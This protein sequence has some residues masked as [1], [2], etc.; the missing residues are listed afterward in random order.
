MVSELEEIMGNAGFGELDSTEFE[1]KEEYLDYFIYVKKAFKALN[2]HFVTRLNETSNKK[3][4]RSV[5]TFFITRLQRSIELLNLKYQYDLSHSVRID[6]T[7]S[8]FPNHAELRQMK[9]DYNLKEQFIA[10]LPNAL[11]LKDRLISKLRS[12]KEEPYEILDALS[13]RKYFNNLIPSAIYLMYNTGKMMEIGI[14][15]NGRRSLIYSWSTYDMATNRP[16]VY[17][18]DFEYSGGAEKFDKTNEHFKLFVDILESVAMGSK[19]CYEIIS[20]MDQEMPFLHPKLLKKY[21]IGP[22]Y[23]A[24]SKD[25]H[26]FSKFHKRHKLTKDHFIVYYEE[27]VI[28]SVKEELIKANWISSKTPLQKFHINKDDPECS[29]RKVSDINKYLIAPHT[30]VQ[31]LLDDPKMIKIITPLRDNLVAI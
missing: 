28:A 4:E 20:F 3:V 21:D 24:Y 6:L 1:R 7:D 30:V 17:V 27:E 25:E 10:N 31:L 29:R 11:V 15:E 5:I 16:M 9:A 8:S 22:L 14:K 12:Q 13:K 18:L 19:S 23:G 26:A 2:E